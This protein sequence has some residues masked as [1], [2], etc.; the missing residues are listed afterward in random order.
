[1]RRFV[2]VG[3]RACASADFR[4]DDLPGTSGRLDVLV[5]CLRAALLVSHGVRQD[6]IVYLVLGGGVPA[7]RV[8]R[9]EGAAARFLRPDERSL[10]TLVK[11]S[12][13]AEAE[14]ESERFVEVRP[15]IAV[16][17]GGLELVL[18]DL[19]DAVL[20]LLEP[21]GADV[22]SEPALDAAHVA[23]FVGDHSGFDD[24]ER[25]WL[26]DLGAR[27]VAVGPV[28]LHAEDAVTIVSN[29]MDRREASNSRR[30][31]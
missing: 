28:Q 14:G 17:R 10:A 26:I 29:E 22:R 11:K 1:M 30:A 12:L 21:A 4:L 25:R 7:K 3:Q 24:V 27:A 13:A 23:F 19:G 15:G 9:V 5:R 2:I 31:R 18:A 16:R 8:V 6:A 20:V